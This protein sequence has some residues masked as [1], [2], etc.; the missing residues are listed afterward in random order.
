MFIEDTSIYFSNMLWNRNFQEESIL[1]HVYLMFLAEYVIRCACF[2]I[3]ST[4]VYTK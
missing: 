2:N 1:Q 4:D 3:S